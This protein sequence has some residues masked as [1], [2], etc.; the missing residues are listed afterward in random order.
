MVILLFGNPFYVVSINKFRTHFC[1][2]LSLHFNPVSCFSRS[3]YRFFACCRVCKYRNSSLVLLPS[4]SKLAH[5][6]GK[7]LFPPL[8]DVAMSERSSA[9]DWRKI[10]FATGGGGGWWWKAER[11]MNPISLTFAL[12]V[13]ES[14]DGGKKFVHCALSV[15][16]RRRSRKTHHQGYWLRHFSS[17]LI[18]SLSH[19]KLSW[20]NEL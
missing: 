11:N 9:S 18:L 2:L 15:G 16:F 6:M 3:F 4:F 19:R 7:N 8:F 14:S 20:R 17:L 12:R 13:G 10:W 1:R 5:V